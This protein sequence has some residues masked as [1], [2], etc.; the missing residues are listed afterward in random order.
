MGD[1]LENSSP[2][3]CKYVFVVLVLMVSLKM[4]QKHEF[5]TKNNKKNEGTAQEKKIHQHRPQIE[6]K[7]LN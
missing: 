3:N 1:L 5:K 4:K 7:T 2:A 6:I